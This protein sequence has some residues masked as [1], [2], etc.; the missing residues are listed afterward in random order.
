MSKAGTLPGIYICQDFAFDYLIDEYRNLTFTKALLHPAL[1]LLAQY[2]KSNQT[3]MYNSLYT[4]L[5]FN[6]DILRTANE[7]HIHRNTLKYRLHRITELTGLNLQD[8][9]DIRYLRLSFWLA[10]TQTR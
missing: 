6:L 9:Q 7:L 8:Q 10:D 2:D 4:F 5:E 3:N 1:Q